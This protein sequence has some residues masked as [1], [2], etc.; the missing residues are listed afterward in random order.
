MQ[1][2]AFRRVRLGFLNPLLYTGQFR[3]KVVNDILIGSNQGCGTDGFEADYGW[4]PVRPAALVSFP[5]HFQCWLI[6]GSILGYGSWDAKRSKDDDV[7][8]RPR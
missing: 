7:Q 2:A 6:L 5:S 8:S 4:D 3:R 1:T